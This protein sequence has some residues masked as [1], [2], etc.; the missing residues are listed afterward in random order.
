MSTMML[1]MSLLAGG[2]YTVTIDDCGGL[3]ANWATP[4]SSECTGLDRHS[5][6]DYIR[7]INGDCPCE[8][9]V[10]FPVGS[11]RV[12][13]P[14]VHDLYVVFSPSGDMLYLRRGLRLDVYQRDLGNGELTLLEVF[15]FQDGDTDPESL[16][17]RDTHY[18]AMSPDGKFLYLNGR[19]KYS[20]WNIDPENGRLTLQD[21]Y[22]HFTAPDPEFPVNPFITLTGNGKFIIF[23]AQYFQDPNT[24]NV[25]ERD[26]AT[27]LLSL[28]SSTTE[29]QPGVPFEVIKRTEY[30]PETRR[31]YVF[32][33]ALSDSSVVFITIYLVDEETGALTK[34]EDL[35]SDMTGYDWAHSGWRLFFAPGIHYVYIPAHLRRLVI[36]RDRDPLYF[37]RYES[38]IEYPVVPGMN[39]FN[40]V[41]NVSGTRAYVSFNNNSRIEVF[42]RDPAD[43]SLTSD[44][45]VCY[46]FPDGVNPDTKDLFLSPDGNFLFQSSE[47][48]TEFFLNWFRVQS[49]E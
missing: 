5:V 23:A 29:R 30:N 28:V 4:V 24:L 19:A 2:P 12:S 45:L 3:H 9:A 39:P 49:D 7:V 41:F 20:L 25:F 36:A 37:L 40:V 1:L 22:A 32:S 21:V 10:L 42:D 8:G 14:D 48:K 13:E 15:D 18:P 27:G 31:L 26:E 6:F 47:T 35:N 43:G 38:E 33:H 44:R 11:V 17:I 16:A 34:L 46:P